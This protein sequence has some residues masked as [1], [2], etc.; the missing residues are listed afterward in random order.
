MQEEIKKTKRK[1]KVPKELRE[2]RSYLMVMR[3]RG[4]PKQGTVEFWYF[5]VLQRNNIDPL[6]VTMDHPEY[7]EGGSLTFPEDFEETVDKGE[8]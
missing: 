1:K 2:F 7:G 6:T 8:V 5:K 4:M 3:N